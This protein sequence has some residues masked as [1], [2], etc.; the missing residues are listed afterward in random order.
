MSPEGSFQ[1]FYKQQI[2]PSQASVALAYCHGENVRPAFMRSVVNAI[3]TDRGRNLR[4][5]ITSEGLYVPRGRNEIV[6]QFLKFSECEWLWFLDTDV[7]FPPDT[8]NRLLAAGSDERKILAAPYWSIGEDGPYCTWM[9]IDDGALLPYREIP[10]KGVL[11]LD[12]CGMGCT[13]IYRDVFVD[14]AKNQ[15][16]G[17]PWTWFGHDLLETERGLTR[18]GEDISFCIRALRVGHATWGVCDISVDHLKLRAAPRGRVG[19]DE[20][21]QA[22]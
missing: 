14:V 19:G 10:E 9:G 18:L 6:S 5:F 8:L 11:K 17:D 7:A 1:R 22:A 20:P 16:E 3:A 15:D 12:A 2:A 13:L 4:G 21:T